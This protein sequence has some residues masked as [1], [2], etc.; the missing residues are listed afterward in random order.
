MIET[1]AMLASGTFLTCTA[2]VTRL[3]GN[4]SIHRNECIAAQYAGVFVVGVAIL[5]YWLGVAA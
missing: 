1:L 3:H 5:Y 4:G 2:T